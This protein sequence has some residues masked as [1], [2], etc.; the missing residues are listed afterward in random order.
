MDFDM[1]GVAF[2]D[3]PWVLPTRRNDPLKKEIFA[4]WPQSSDKYARL[5]ALGIDAFNLIPDLNRLISNR[6][7]YHD[8]TTGHLYLDD[9]NRVFRRL[10]WAEFKQGKPQT[11][12]N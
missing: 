5:F 2:G 6:T 4:L 12:D 7:N 9:S 11:I 3:M 8:G 10:V 1:D